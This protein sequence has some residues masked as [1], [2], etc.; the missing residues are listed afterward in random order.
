MLAIAIQWDQL[1]V[2]AEVKRALSKL[3]EIEGDPDRQKDDL[4]DIFTVVD[5]INAHVDAQRATLIAPGGKIG[6]L[7]SKIFPKKLDT[8]TRTAPEGGAFPIVGGLTI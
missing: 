4:G 6:A 2:A 7:G 5:T 1:D 3:S 8:N